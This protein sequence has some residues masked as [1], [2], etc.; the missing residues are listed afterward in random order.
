MTST[1]MKHKNAAVVKSLSAPCEKCEC[2][3]EVCKTRVGLINVH[4]LNDR[5]LDDR[6]LHCACRICVYLWCWPSH[7]EC[8][9]EELW[10]FTL[11]VNTSTKFSAV[12]IWKS[13]S[14]G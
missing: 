10:E 4:V 11:E 13:E 1:W 2:T 6:E 8:T 7:W 9:E 3:A 14:D 12:G 5:M